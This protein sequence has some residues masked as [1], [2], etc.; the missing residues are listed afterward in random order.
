MLFLNIFKV[1]ALAMKPWASM[2]Q[3]AVFPGQ[4][5][6]ASVCPLPQQGHQ[7]RRTVQV[8]GISGQLNKALGSVGA[9]VSGAAWGA[10][11]AFL[12]LLRGVPNPS[13]QPGDHT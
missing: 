6:L 9:E 5:L 1:R 13:S 3:V 7:L 8:C 11:G 12:S 4:S 2:R 10:L